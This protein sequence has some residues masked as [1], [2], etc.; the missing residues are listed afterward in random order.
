MGDSIDI[1]EMKAIAD[2][3]IAFKLVW[4]RVA[5]YFLIPFFTTF[6]ALTETWSQQTWLDTGNFLKARLFV[7]CFVSG[8]TSLVAFIDSS[9]Q[10]SKQV[11][12]DLRAKRESDTQF[13]K[14]P[15]QQS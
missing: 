2:T 15:E 3:I 5:C 11:A 14:Q 6:L 13:I 4:F 9:F 10:K 8:V 1:Q 7:S 12:Q